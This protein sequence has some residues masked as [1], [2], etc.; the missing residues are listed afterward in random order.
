LIGTSDEAK[1]AIATDWEQLRDL[2]LLLVATGEVL[3][4]PFVEHIEYLD[5]AAFGAT[6]G[7]PTHEHH[8]LN[9]RAKQQQSRKQQILAV[10]PPNDLVLH[11]VSEKLILAEPHYIGP[12]LIFE[13]EFD[14]FF[15]KALDLW[16]SEVD[17]R[18]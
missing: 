7:M 14:D 18:H 9:W 5:A 13:L 8:I 11:I 6:E 4:N 1:D 12:K 2:G 17:F 3:D 16:L 15:A 10:V